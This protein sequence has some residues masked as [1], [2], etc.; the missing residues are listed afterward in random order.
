MHNDSQHGLTIDLNGPDGNAF[1]L[2]GYAKQYAR[3]LNKNGKEIIAEMTQSDYNAL[4]EVFEREFPMITLLNNPNEYEPATNMCPECEG[5][6]CEECD[7]T[8][9]IFE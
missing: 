1:A 9:E 4:L 6:G 8:G 2:M 7:F 3:E 5:T